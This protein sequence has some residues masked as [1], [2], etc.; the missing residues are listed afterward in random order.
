MDEHTLITRYTCWICYG[1]PSPGHGCSTPYLTVTTDLNLLSLAPLDQPGKL[2][3]SVHS[4]TSG[5]APSSWML[6]ILATKC[7]GYHITGALH[8]SSNTK[9]IF[10]HLICTHPHHVL[11]MVGN[12][13]QFLLDFLEGNSHGYLVDF[14][15]ANGQ[16]LPT[17]RFVCHICMIPH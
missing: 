13:P 6:S 17:D 5:A 10:C 2:L 4:S 15:S 9:Y 1:H 3:H 16:D 11:S 7:V 8:Q 14:T 12:S